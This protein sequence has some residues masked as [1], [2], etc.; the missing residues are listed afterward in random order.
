MSNMIYSSKTYP[1]FLQH[2]TL[3]FFLGFSFTS[4]FATCGGDFV[5]LADDSELSIS[6]DMFGA[7]GGPM[8]A[9]IVEDMK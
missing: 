6:T 5:I 8:T 9:I 7:M 2:K 4:T 1:S 3:F